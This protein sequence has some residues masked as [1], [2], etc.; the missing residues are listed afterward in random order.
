MQFKKM[1]SWRFS[2]K[3]LR[4]FS[5]ILQNRKNQVAEWLKVIGWIQRQDRFLQDNKI[6]SKLFKS[7]QMPIISAAHL[8]S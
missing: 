8:I 2:S 6:V 3:K 5:L 1:L 7:W 4:M